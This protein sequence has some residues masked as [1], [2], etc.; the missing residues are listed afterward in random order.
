MIIENFKMHCAAIKINKIL[1]LSQPLKFFPLT[2][3]SKNDF[4]FVSVFV[5]QKKDQKAL[6]RLSG[7]KPFF[8]FF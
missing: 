2:D 7:G 4:V 5:I 6:M 1:L 8:F 3:V